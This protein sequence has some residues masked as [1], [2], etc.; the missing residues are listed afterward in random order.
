[1]NRVDVLE[2]AK[3]AITRD[4][5]ATHGDAEDSFQDIADFW[6]IWL[7]KRLDGEITPFDVAQM[8]QLFKSARAKGNPTHLD[9]IVDQVGYSALSVEMVPGNDKAWHKPVVADEAEGLRVPASKVGR[10]CHKR[11][12][13]SWSHECG[14]LACRTAAH[15]AR[16]E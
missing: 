11:V 12:G 7:G 13:E 15:E 1:M 2:T 4:R 6:T 8:M 10:G 5:A 16:F 9:N 14:C 3:D